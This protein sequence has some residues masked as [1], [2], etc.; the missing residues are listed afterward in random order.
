MGKKFVPTRKQLHRLTHIASQ[1][2]QN[3]HI[4]PDSLVRDLHYLHLEEGVPL[5]CTKKTILRDIK[6][7]K[8]EFGCPVKFSRSDQ[9]YYL[10]HHGWDFI[11]PALIDENEMLAAVVGAKIATD[12]FP[13][14]IRSRITNAVD[15][16]LKAN[17]PD[18]LDT[19]YIDSLK[20]FANVSVMDVSETF[21][22]VFE[23]WQQHHTIYIEYDDMN[24]HVS[25]REVDPHVLVFFD[26]QWSIK[27]FC[28]L[29]QSFRTFIISRIVK[30]QM[31]STTFT[32]NR[33]LIDG[34]T[35]DSFLSF[36]KVENV[37]IRLSRNARKF[38]VSNRM[39]TK[40]NISSEKGLDTFMLIIP[41]VSLEV[42]VPW[43][44]S[45]KGDAVP[46]EPREVVEAVKTAAQKIANLCKI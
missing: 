16:L 32:P 35:L 11:C 45:Q 7:L 3:K 13:D 8:E 24:G 19:T 44:L 20:I 46:L 12:L 28:H 42:V 29:R 4:T 1:L 2:K 33:K 27:A 39:H 5:S 23:A 37:K 36:H 41:A 40:Q 15:E 14:P 34:V 26:R 9:S 25:Q 18:F 10:S 17:N 6:A 38:A 30:A 22:V 21:P 43:I 31:Q